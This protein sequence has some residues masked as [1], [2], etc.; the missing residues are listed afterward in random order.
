M[1]LMIEEKSREKDENVIENP[2]KDGENSENYNN[3]SRGNKKT[4][5]KSKNFKI[6]C[7]KK[8]LKKKIIKTYLSI[9]CLIYCW[10]GRGINF[11]VQLMSY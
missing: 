9:I 2:M 4:K 3:A 6:I 11:P 10:V 8:I 1:S 5:T 7:L